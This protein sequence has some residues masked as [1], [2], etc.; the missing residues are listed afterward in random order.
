MLPPDLEQRRVAILAEIEAAFRSASRRGGVSWTE[1]GAIDDYGSEQ[2][3]ATAQALDQDTHWSELVNDAEWDPQEQHWGG[4]HFL[5]AIGFRYYLPALMTRSLQ[6][7]PHSTMFYAIAFGWND[8]DEPRSRNKYEKFDSR[9]LRCVA[10]FVRFAA[11]HQ[12][13]LE[14]IDPHAHIHS[15]PWEG[16]YESGWKRLDL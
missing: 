15:M 6:T 7:R 1:T 10:A 8:P 9:Q 5:D 4:F 13:W 12:K 16:L 3:R 14:S 11:D 2:D